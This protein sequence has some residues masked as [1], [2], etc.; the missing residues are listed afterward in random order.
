MD[1]FYSISL[2]FI[3][4]TLLFFYSAI[5][6]NNLVHKQHEEFFQKRQAELK[7]EL[8]KNQAKLK[9]L[10]V[11]QQ[12]C[13]AKNI[14]FEARGESKLGQIAIARVVINRIKAGFGRNPCSVINQANYVE[15]V[16]DD[17]EIEKIKVCQ[18]SWVCD[19]QAVLNR[20]NPLYKQALQI[21]HD[22]LV[23]DAHN[24]ILPKNAL[25]FH[26]IL[27]QPEWN[28]RQVAKIG[29]HIFYSKGRK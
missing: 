20:N 16:N 9:Q 1:K 25:F 2:K 19:Q 17:G 29:N 21:A 13:L 12:E 4:M 26:S 18:F 24:D 15:S 27:V 22:V 3:V 23:H 5:T 8:E 28:L 14:Y 6:T 11:R 10:D 7:F